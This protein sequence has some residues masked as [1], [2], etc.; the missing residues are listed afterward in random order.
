M[1]TFRITFQNGCHKC[2]FFRDNVFNNGSC[3][4]SNT[5]P[6]MPKLEPT[7][8]GIPEKCPLTRSE[9]IVEFANNKQST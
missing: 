7:V 6:K 2:P 9:I 3:N 5:H 8:N 4:I 1:K